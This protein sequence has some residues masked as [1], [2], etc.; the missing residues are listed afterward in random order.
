MPYPACVRSLVVSLALVLLVGCSEDA[1][2]V[3][4]RLTLA[5]DP[6]CAPPEPIADLRIEALGDFPASDARTVELLDPEGGPAL[7]D[8]FP[9]A[10][11]FVAVTATG[12]RW[13]GL[14]LGPLGTARLLVQPENQPCL[15]PDPLLAAPGRGVGVL[16]DGSLVLAGGRADLGF[17]DR[18]VLRYV[19]G[20]TLAEPLG[21][22]LVERRFEPAVALVG[23]RLFVVGGGADE[24]GG[25]LDTFEV[26]DDA[27][28][29]SAA[30]QPLDGPRREA[31]VTAL[32]RRTL[33]VAGGRVFP[34]DTGEAGAPLASVL[35]V[36]ALS[37]TV[38]A[39]APLPVARARPTLL[40]LDD[41]AVLLVGG[42]GPGGAELT[43]VLVFDG[44]LEAFVPSGERVAPFVGAAQAVAL[45]GS[46]AVVFGAERPA[47]L[48]LFERVPPEASLRPRLRRTRLDLGAVLPPLL[49]ARAVALE[50]GRLLLTGRGEDGAARAF[51]LDLGALSVDGL[52]EPGR[53]AT[54]LAGSVGI[55]AWPAERA[56]EALHTLPG[57]MV[58]ALDEEGAW[59]RRPALTSLFG[60]PP[61]SLFLEDLRAGGP[62]QWAQE[63]AALVARR[64]EARLELPSLRFAGVELEL[65]VEGEAELLLRPAGTAAVSVLFRDLGLARG[66]QELA[67][68]A[69]RLVIPRGAPVRIVRRGATVRLLPGVEGAFAGRGCPAPE[70]GGD[71]A[72]FTDTAE[73]GLGV[74]VGVALRAQPNAR[75]RG[76]RVR[77]LPPEP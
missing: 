44:E 43:D 32:G 48:E 55:E 69:C 71:F 58:A 76:L 41:G 6:R 29:V 60:S 30:P 26:F 34:E 16:P 68:G 47:Q 66:E 5:S 52:P 15:V 61:A 45:P 13:R 1:A 72:R 7:I 14:G 77:R 10:T 20:E 2:P 21:E 17:G 35:R 46:R 53:A 23:A 8:R 56:P 3:E 37:F 63:G 28:R 27:G 49:Y 36:D 18:R 38:R 25:G 39:L 50:D 62:G 9:E 51:V 24:T 4:V 12:P 11:R 59:L 67:V 19:P 57:G 22:G 42:R 73:L 31:G 40:R 74:L 33:L 65:R 75:I 64:D 70:L 54:V